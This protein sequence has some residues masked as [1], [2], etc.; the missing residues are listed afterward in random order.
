M[1]ERPMNL[2]Q[3]LARIRELEADRAAS[4]RGERAAGSPSRSFSSIAAG[5]PSFKKG[6]TVSKTGVYTLHAGERVIPAPSTRLHGG[7][8]TCK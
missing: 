5:P 4:D 8:R 6:G 7:K 2:Q 1:A 3:K